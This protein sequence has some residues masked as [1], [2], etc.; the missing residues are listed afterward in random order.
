MI[1]YGITVA[2]EFF[3]FKRLINSLEPYVLPDEEIVI[4]A[5]QN[6][7]T[8]EIEEFCELCGL[9]V[10]YFDFQKDFSEFKNTLFDLSTKDYLM[11]IDADEQIPP[12]LLHAL[13]TVGQQ[14]PEIDLLWI[15]RINVVRGATGEHVKKYNWKIDDM[16]WEGFPDFQSRFASTKGHIKWQNKVHEVLVGSN[17]PSKLLEFPVENFSIL[18]VKDIQKQEKQ[19]DLYDTI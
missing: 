10:N 8:K 15:P 12:S 19:N 13:R 1:T 16:G 11:Q 4:L 17:N 6:K 9:E 3:E 5:D 18:H 7:V 14:K 2:D